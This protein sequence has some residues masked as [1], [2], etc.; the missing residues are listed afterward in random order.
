MSIVQVSY[1]LNHHLSRPGD[2]KDKLVVN[3]GHSEIL[4]AALG[5][6][7]FSVLL[8]RPGLIHVFSSHFW[9]DTFEHIGNI[10]SPFA[11]QNS[12]MNKVES[13]EFVHLDIFACFINILTWSTLSFIKDLNQLVKT[14]LYTN[15]FHFCFCIDCIRKRVLFTFSFDIRRIKESSDSDPIDLLRCPTGSGI[16]DDASSTNLLPPFHQNGLSLFGKNSRLNI[17]CDILFSH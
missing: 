8:E 4:L 12:R 6:P 13:G 10:E 3:V 7:T 11:R 15:I 14:T 1:R 16:I 9:H 5:I 2:G 17:S